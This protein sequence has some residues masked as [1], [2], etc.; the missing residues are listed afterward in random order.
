MS[1]FRT[2]FFLLACCIGALRAQAPHDSLRALDSA[3]ASFSPRECTGAPLK[4]CCARSSP[5]ALPRRLCAF[6]AWL[7]QSNKTSAEILRDL[8]VRYATLLNDTIAVLAPAPVAE[9][10]EEESPVTITA[11]ASASCS[12]C[13]RVVRELFIAVSAGPLKNKARLAFKP[14]TADVGDRALMAAQ[15]AGRFWDYFS[16]LSMVSVRPTRELLL[17][18][19][20]SLG[21]AAATFARDMDDPSIIIPLNKSIDEGRRN[22]VVVT[23][24]FFI[25]NRRYRSYKDSPWVIDAAEYRFETLKKRGH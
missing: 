1:R 24:T 23:P 22:G 16:A 3:L 14:F 25:N 17:H 8:Q 10:G 5:T 18:I 7:A 21:F 2:V 13:K 20:D 9:A 11:F 19:A 4:A 12:L 15:R 6:G